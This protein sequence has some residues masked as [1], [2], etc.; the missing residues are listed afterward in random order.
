MTDDEHGWSADHP[1]ELYVSNRWPIPGQCGYLWRWEDVQML[2]PKRAIPGGDLCDDHLRDWERNRDRPQV[3][4][5]GDT[6][7]QFPP[8]IVTRPEA[9]T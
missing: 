6:V 8:T 1:G 3:G 5:G 9:T 2:C 4:D 7:R